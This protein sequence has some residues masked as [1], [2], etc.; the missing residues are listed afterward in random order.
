MNEE[1]DEDHVKQNTSKPKSFLKQSN[2]KPLNSPTKLATTLESD[3]FEN[4]TNFNNAGITKKNM[5]K[6]GSLSNRYSD[7]F[8]E[9]NLNEDNNIPKLSI[10]N[11]STN[12]STQLSSILGFL[13]LYKCNGIRKI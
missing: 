1:Q 10:D 12:S 3:E 11:N 6:N 9:E 13:S 5:L 8:D 7:D 2:V 4:T